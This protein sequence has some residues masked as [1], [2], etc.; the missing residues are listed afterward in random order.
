MSFVPA[1]IVWRGSSSATRARRER[2]IGIDAEI[3]RIA[4]GAT[5]SG[6]TMSMVSGPTRVCD[7]SS[8]R[9]PT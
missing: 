9:V 8:G 3:G 4:R 1:V 5:R 2:D 7:R 6:S